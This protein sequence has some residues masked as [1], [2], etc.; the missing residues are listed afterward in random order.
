MVNMSEQGKKSQAPKR[1]KSLRNIGTVT[2]EGLFSQ[3]IGT[4]EQ[5]R[6]A[7]E[8]ELYGKLKLW[9]VKKLD[10]CVLYRFQAAADVP[11]QV[12]EDVRGTGRGKEVV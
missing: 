6:Q 11:C 3:G 2:A 8:E 9:N 4:Q 1:L 7:D 12:C 5:T 10:R